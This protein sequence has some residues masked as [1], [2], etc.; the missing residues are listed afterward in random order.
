VLKEQAE[1]TPAISPV[2][3]VTMALGHWAQ[4]RECK[5]IFA[6]Y[7]TKRLKFGLDPGLIPSPDNCL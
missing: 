6:I 1:P 7:Y 3:K 5:I 2:L 4:Q